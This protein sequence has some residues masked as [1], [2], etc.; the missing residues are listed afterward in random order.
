MRNLLGF[1]GRRGVALPNGLAMLATKPALMPTA[2]AGLPH[3]DSGSS[4]RNAMALALGSTFSAAADASEAGRKTGGSE[5]A[6]ARASGTASPTSSAN[7]CQVGVITALPSAGDSA[8]G[9][10][11]FGVSTSAEGLSLGTQ[12]GGN[13]R[14]MSLLLLRVALEAN[15][16]FAP[17]LPQGTLL[18]CVLEHLYL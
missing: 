16:S 12:C 15:T 5:V 2:A 1:G 4:E 13:P 7:A 10:G 3:T 14:S 9:V 18:Q 8:G 6:G 17:A 11:A